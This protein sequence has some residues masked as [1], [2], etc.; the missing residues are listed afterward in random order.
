[1]LGSA[2]AE[3]RRGV[4][5]GF[6]EGER[7]AT[8]E[9]VGT[10]TTYVPGLPVATHVPSGDL[11]DGAKAVVILFDCHNPADSVVVGVYGLE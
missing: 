7:T 9:L 11:V 2:G 8:V 10:V 3:I 5:R 1:M 4:V 6:D